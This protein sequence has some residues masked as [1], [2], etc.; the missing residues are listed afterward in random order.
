MHCSEFNEIERQKDICLILEK[1]MWDQRKSYIMLLVERQDT[2]KNSKKK[3]TE[4][5]KPP[6]LQ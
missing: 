5:E 4:I 2:N 3:K 1:M 6:K